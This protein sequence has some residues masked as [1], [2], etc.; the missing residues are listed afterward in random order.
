MDYSLLVGIHFIDPSMPKEIPVFE[1]KFKHLLTLT[2]FGFQFPYCCTY[3]MH[4]LIED[5]IDTDNTKEVTPRLS[6]VDIDQFLCDP[7]R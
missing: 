3:T 1:G 7:S 6:R 2:N 4:S 5:N